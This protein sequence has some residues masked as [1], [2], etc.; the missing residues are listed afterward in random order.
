MQTY[1]GTL[2]DI[3]TYAYKS[4]LRRTHNSSFSIDS[5]CII[6]IATVQLDAQRAIGKL[7]LVDGTEYRI[8][9]SGTTWALE[10]ND[11][12][13]DVNENNVMCTAVKSR[14]KF[15]RTRLVIRANSRTLQMQ[16]SYR[17]GSKVYV[18][19]DPALN[20]P[21]ISIKH[22]ETR[23]GIFNTPARSF[24]LQH[25][26]HLNTQDISHELLGFI[27]GLYLIFYRRSHGDHRSF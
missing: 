8:T 13:S 26:K 1:T 21:L 25:N 19:Y 14:S 12:S 5:D 6:R 17:S 22:T 20:C 4:T 3:Y 7:T 10:S 18:V 9:N 15:S 27:Y 11:I 2:D 16:T 24:I 23:T